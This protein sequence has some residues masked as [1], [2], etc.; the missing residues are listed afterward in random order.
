MIKHGAMVYCKIFLIWVYVEIFLFLLKNFLKLR[1]FQ[2]CLGTILSDFYL[3]EEGIPQGS[4][5]S[6]T[7]FSI[8]INNILK[9]LPSTVYGSLHVDNLQISCQGKDVCFIERQLQI[10][11]SN[12]IKWTDTNGFNFSSDKTCCVHF[13]CIQGF[14]LTQSF[15]LM[16]DK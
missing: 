13:C 12:I 16:E 11:I 14:I 5:L 1:R 3:Q 9:Q 8:K 15:L 4:V 2:I 7:L 6:V 10:A